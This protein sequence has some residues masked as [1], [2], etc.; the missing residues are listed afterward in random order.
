MKVPKQLI[1]SQSLWAGNLMSLGSCEGSTKALGK[2]RLNLA[3]ICWELPPTSPCSPHGNGKTWS[4]RNPRHVLQYTLQVGKLLW[5]KVRNGLYLV[6]IESIFLFF[7]IWLSSERGK[8]KKIHLVISVCCSNQNRGSFP[9][10]LFK[11]SQVLNE[12]WCAEVEK[13]WNI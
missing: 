12:Q 4:S 8:M 10:L 9:T 2:T 11:E 6:H 5:S 13:T 7:L 1:Q 3:L